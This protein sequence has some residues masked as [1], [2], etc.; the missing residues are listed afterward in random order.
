V[1]GGA[2]NHFTKRYSEAT[3][4]TLPF[5]NENVLLEQV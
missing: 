5:Y 3:A 2:L 4:K 1:A